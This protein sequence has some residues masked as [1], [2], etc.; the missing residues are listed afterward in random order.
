MSAGIVPVVITITGESTVIHT[1]KPCIFCMKES[2]TISKLN[3]TTKRNKT[4]RK[5][6]FWRFVYRTKGHNDT[7]K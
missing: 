2:E 3:N 6:E 7:N 1:A 5:K 4:K